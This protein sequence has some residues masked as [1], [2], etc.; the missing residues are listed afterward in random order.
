MKALKA[1][2]YRK[3]K[4]VTRTMYFKWCG[5][6]VVD[7]ICGSCQAILV[8]GHCIH[9]ERTQLKKLEKIKQLQERFGEGGDTHPDLI[10]TKKKKSKAVHSPTPEGDPMST[11]KKAKRGNGV[12]KL[13]AE[14]AEHYKKDVDKLRENAKRN[15]YKE[16][17]INIQIQRL[18]SAGL[19]PKAEKVP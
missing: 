11:A 16:S 3:R 10:P 13:F 18:R 4:N 2:D 19:L 17:T 1:A 8:E 5:K 7:Q 9:C 14:Q 15:K 6:T 12:I